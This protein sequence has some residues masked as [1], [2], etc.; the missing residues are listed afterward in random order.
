MKA[1]DSTS[2]RP[3]LYTIPPSAPFLTSLARAV[4][5]SVLPVAGGPK[6]DRLT[7]PQ[8]TIYLPTRRAARGLR[9]AFLSVSGGEA[10]LLPRI[11]TLGD[12]DEDE[13]IIFAAGDLTGDRIDAGA[14][15]PTIG[16][17]ERR[18]VLMRLI[19]AWS[20]TARREILRA[21]DELFP[22]TPLVTTAA[23]ASNLAADLARLMD[24]VESEEVDLGA[25]QALVPEEFAAH[26]QLTVN[27]LKIVTEA[28]PP[29][30]ADRKLVSPVGRRNL[31]MELE[32]EH[33]AASPPRGPVIA[34]GSTGTVPATARLLQVIASLPNGAVVLPGLDLD[35]D[36]ASWASVAT[37]AEHPQSGMAELLRKLG[38]GRDEV[39]FVPGSMPDAGQA[40]RLRFVSE[41]LRPS[42]TTELWQ[43]FLGESPDVGK[44][45]SSLHAIE[46]PTAQDEAEAIAL[47]LRSTIETK[48]KTAAL[49]TPDRTL[50]RR[51]AARLK[52]FGLAI[53]DSAGTPV[54]RTVPGAFLD[55]VLEAVE[56]DF[57][58]AALMALL[59]HPALL[60][61]RRPG[62]IR[63]AARRLERTLFRDIYLGRGLDG[64]QSALTG[65]PT[66]DNTNSRR[67]ISGKMR[68]D[69]SQLI[70]DLQSAFAPLT[71]LLA[72][73]GPHSV[74][75]QAEGHSAAAERLARDE[76]GSSAKLWAGD[77]GE[78]LSLLLAKLMTEG[79]SV[80]IDAGDYPAF[81]RGLVANEVVR[82]RIQAHPRLSIW[83]PLEA[84]LQQPDVVILGGLNEGTWPRPQDAGPWLSRP[85][86][87]DLGLPTP[88]RRIGLSA[89]D[90]AQGLGAR[91]VY[92]TRALKVDGVATVP[93]RWLQRL[94][95]LAAAAMSE[96]RLAPDQ[97]WVA[98]CRARDRVANFTPVKAPKPC[99]PLEARPRGLSV[100][101]IE[102]W[103]ANPYE[104]FARDILGLK[105]LKP[106]GAEPD[107]ALRGQI[108]HRMLQDFAERHPDILPADIEAELVEAAERALAAF[109]DNA[110]VTALWRPQF[111]CFAS[112]FA[113]TEPSRRAHLEKTLTEISGSWTIPV[114]AGFTLST[115]ADRIDILDDGTAAIY[116]Y[117]TGTPPNSKRVAELVAPQ[118]PLEA[119]I[120]MKG[121]FTALG[122]REPSGLHYIYISGR[123]DGGD[124]QDAADAT[125]AK[126]LAE[127]ALESLTKLIEHFDDPTTPYEVKRR[128]GAFLSAYRY[129]DYEQLARVKEWAILAGEEELP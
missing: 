126:A 70:A 91:T 35:L 47:I 25:L 72:A 77:A 94:N 4:L 109:N 40:M 15:A 3:R 10:L 79:A 118:L 39:K 69:L 106:L 97:P 11:R 96:S 92:L 65:L 42:G 74:A 50:A 81:Y 19:L 8:T 37:H 57:A 53:D 61:G 115:R 103:I 41:A 30:L 121:G 44:A 88:E 84:R 119:A 90:F 125:K 13:A 110:R 78:A 17:L 116:D 124:Q 102:R 51:V 2:P 111:R 34:A 14:G 75:E 52:G 86:L 114:G 76:T 38:V 24:F 32:A 71:D 9:E 36:D 93:S 83:G 104:I 127:N 129:D 28:W 66:D 60:L 120:L 95:A 56:A 122:L 6:P 16:T 98:W 89:H 23:Q 1:P 113:A 27:F 100:S 67:G 59:K 63:A 108:A 31:L 55:L 107:A 87:G 73:P 80:E 33:L 29:Y 117:K 62:D 85:M 54:V 22:V 49:V 99:P 105:P 7:L 18:L 46:A 26:W 123:L 45:L 64:V 68:Q 112:W 5:D 12:P 20:R 82:P 101:R 43:D 58:P 128:P 21:A 48:G